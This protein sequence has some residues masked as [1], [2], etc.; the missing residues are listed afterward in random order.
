MDVNEEEEK[1]DME[2]IIV[3]VAF[4]IQDEG[5]CVPDIR[6]ISTASNADLSERPIHFWSVCCETSSAKIECKT[7]RY[8][9]R[10]TFN[11]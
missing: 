4:G 8:A 10:E 6:Y 9:L 3:R 11:S 2:F 7:R 1:N 5:A